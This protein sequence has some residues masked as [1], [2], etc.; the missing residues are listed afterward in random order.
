MFN[1][2]PDQPRCEDPKCEDLRANSD[3]IEHTHA[4]A[5]EE[6]VRA[7]SAQKGEPW[8]VS[9]ND[10]DIGDTAVAET[11]GT[12]HGGTNETNATFSIS[13][14]QFVQYV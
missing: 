2:W 4:Q 3:L 5:W 8:K 10:L 13:E 11:K 9:T 12:N 1:G 7:P 6:K 14:F